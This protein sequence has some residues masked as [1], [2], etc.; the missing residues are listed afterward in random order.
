M[1]NKNNLEKS[2]LISL[3]G[4]K[5]RD[6][7]SKLKEIEQ[8][9][10]KRIAL[11]LEIF[12]KKQ[13]PKIYQALLNSV[14]KEI[15]LVHI[16]DDMTNK[17]LRFLQENYKTK[18]FNIHENHFKLLNKWKGFYKYLYLE[19]NYDNIVNQYVKVKKIGGFCVD[20]SHFKAAQDRDT[21]EFDY[22]N[23]RK[24]I[25]RYFK[26]N[27]LNGYDFT[28]KIDL[29]TVI[30]VKQFDYLKTL[31]AYLYGQYIGLEVF[32]SIKEQLKFKKYIINLLK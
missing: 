10:I 2:I 12:D 23:K 21:I 17:D 3:T 22:I 28:K 25:H 19:M 18:C 8:L 1:L 6:W 15:P 11:F 20:L 9:K 30:N 14:I 29:H 24:D 27:H 32:N 7:Q 4:S 31:P 16:K 5:E 26:C 13:R